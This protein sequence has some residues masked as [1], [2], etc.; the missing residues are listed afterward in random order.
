MKLKSIVAD[1]VFI[2]IVTAVLVLL[3]ETGQLQAVARYPFP[4]I[5]GA[6][7]TGRIAGELSHRARRPG[8]G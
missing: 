8:R 1:L 7:L 4:V 5:L 3:S 2:L 6:Y